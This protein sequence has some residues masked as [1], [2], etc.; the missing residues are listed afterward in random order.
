MPDPTHAL[1]ALVIGRDTIQIEDEE[2]YRGHPGVAPRGHALGV[3]RWRPAATAVLVGEDH[4]RGQELDQ[5]VKLQSSRFHARSIHARKDGNLEE[6]GLQVLRLGRIRFLVRHKPI[7][8]SCPGLVFPTT[9]CLT[10]GMLSARDGLEVGRL[11]APAMPAQVIDGPPGRNFGLL[12]DVQQAMRLAIASPPPGPG[13]AV[14]VVAAFPL[15]AAGGGVGLCYQTLDGGTFRV[16][17]PRFI[18]RSE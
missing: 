10:P 17:C 6:R 18:S 2:R 8:K 16:K 3:P 7:A 14:L 11:D 12:P 13:I 15:P 4:E 5:F 1:Q 9:L